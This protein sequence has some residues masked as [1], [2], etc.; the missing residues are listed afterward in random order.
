[1]SK[2]WRK[3]DDTRQLW[4]G[5]QKSIF[6]IQILKSLLPLKEKVSDFKWDRGMWAWI[7]TKNNARYIIS[8]KVFVII[9]LSI[10]IL[11]S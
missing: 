1:L 5:L 8:R 11:E 6:D 2:G 4:R 3:T 7:W 10:N 9:Y